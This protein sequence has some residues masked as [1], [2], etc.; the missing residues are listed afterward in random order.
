MKNTH[1]M[2]IGLGKSGIAL[3]EYLYEHNE[4]VTA[5]DKSPSDEAKKALQ[6][7]IK[8]Y[9][10][11]FDYSYLDGITELIMSPGVPTKLPFVAKAKELGISVIGEIEFAYRH[12]KGNIIAITGTNGKTTTTTLTGEILKNS[13]F[14][15]F[16]VGN[17]G[18][19]FIS[20][21]N[22]ISEGDAVV[23]EISSYQL[24]TINEFS[25]VSVAIL[26]ITPDHLSRH[27]SM[28]AYIQAKFDCYKNMHKKTV[29]LNADNEITANAQVN[30]NHA[31]FFSIKKTLDVGAWLENDVLMINT[32]D[33]KQEICK[34]S[35]LKILGSHN[36][37][38]AL[39]A[40]LLAKLYGASVGAIRDTLINFYGVE[41]RIEFCGE[42]KGIKFYNDSKG[43]NCD[44]T[45]KA[46]DAMPTKT[47]LILGGF[48]KGGTFD[49][50][51]DHIDEKIKF[52][53]VIGQTAP[54]IL[55]TA[56]RYGYTNIKYCNSFDEAIYEA[57]DA[58]SDGDNVLL[59]PACASWDMFDNFEQ[60][61]RIFKDT[62]RQIINKNN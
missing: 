34:V 51:F 43:T 59:S 19:V 35:E 56:Q 12:C 24:E 58:C 8:I 28:A 3:A 20:Q 60:R 42:T 23:A 45:I 36:V 37:E 2:V 25:P 46:I 11:D 50:L 15:T 33:G 18:N 6:Q 21:A 49:E 4:K 54:L 29:V 26:N 30:D 38:N 57:F 27:G 52:I 22:S 7:K 9:S 41:H 40:A 48:D 47:A 13:G 17:I 39:A 62:V 31:Y 14:K 16:V 1:Y 44:S 5:Y 53:T 55:Q 32:D 10:G 61:G